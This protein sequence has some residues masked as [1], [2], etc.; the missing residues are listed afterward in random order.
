LKVI[1]F[2]LF[3]VEHRLKPQPEIGDNQ[4]SGE[5]TKLAELERQESISRLR[6]IADSAMPFALFSLK[7]RSKLSKK[8]SCTTS[9]DPKIIVA[10][11]NGYPNTAG[12]V[13][14]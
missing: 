9:N 6:N 12:R 2:V 3:A 4:L 10:D 11:E 7:V 8:A 1:G 5:E 13:F 14:V